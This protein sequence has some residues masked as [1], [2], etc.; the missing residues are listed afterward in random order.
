MLPIFVNMDFH[1]LFMLAYL[2]AYI[3]VHVIGTI[4]STDNMTGISEM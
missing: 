3:G 1:K 4:L 2:N